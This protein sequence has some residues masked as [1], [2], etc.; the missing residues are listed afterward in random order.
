VHYVFNP[1]HYI[2]I[3]IAN[4]TLLYKCT[5]GKFKDEKCF[6]D[7]IF[8]PKRVR[9]LLKERLIHVDQ[10]INDA[11]TKSC[12]HIQFLQLNIKIFKTLKKLKR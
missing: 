12:K 7:Y 4:T 1:D 11:I 3:V 10:N 8:F 2:G 5:H 9:R 6:G